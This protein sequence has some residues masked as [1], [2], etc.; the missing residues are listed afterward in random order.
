MKK[1]LVIV[2]FQ[3]DF[4]TG[5]LGFE[6]ALKLEDKI[7]KKIIEYRLL[8]YD[9]IFT[10]DTHDLNYLE[11]NEGRNLPIKHCI[12]GTNG[13]NLYGKIDKMV[14]NTDKAFYKNTFGS[15]ELGEYL[16]NQDYKEIELIG[17]VS[18]ICVITNAIIAKTFVPEAEII[19]DAFCTD[20]FDKTIHEKTLDVL[21]GIQIK[22]KNR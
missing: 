10:Y 22:V 7:A 5:S 12:K 21:E 1:A 13:W 4:V 11:T 14:T 8:N 18:N 3:N 9:I 16:K 17:L 2:D 20:S 19:V 6:S 15:I